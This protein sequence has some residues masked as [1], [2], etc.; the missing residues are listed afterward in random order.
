MNDFSVKAMILAA[1]F[2]TRLKPITDTIP[3]ALLLYNGKTLL[4][5]SLGHLKDHG[6]VDVIIN[7]HHFAGKIIDY[8]SVNNNFGMN[9]ALSDETEQLLD[10]GGGVRKASWFF[11][12][13]HAFIVRNVDVISDLDMN[14]LIKYHRDHS[15]LATLVVRNRVTARY[16]LFDKE[17]MLSGWENNKTGK[18]IISR[19]E[20]G[21]LKPFAFS[22]IQV[23]DP[24]VIELMSEKVKFSLT[25]MYLRLSEEYFIQGY[26]DNESFWH[27][28]G[29][30]ELL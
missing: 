22:G 19:Q 9:I 6:I 28:A 23:M 20:Q 4:E 3:K 2:G 1:G 11:S 25:D 24:H 7:V 17:M 27:D 21:L 13:C 15:S 10:T 29:K 30:F 14:K 5:H 18:R 8:L 16:F 26:L 12:G